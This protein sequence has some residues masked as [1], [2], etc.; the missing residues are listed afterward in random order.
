MS[1][2][3]SD[4]KRKAEEFEEE[5]FG[6]SIEFGV[7]KEKL[8][9]EM[10]IRYI[11][12]DNI[13]NNANNRGKP[14]QEDSQTSSVVWPKRRK[15]QSEVLE[16]HVRA[17]N[18]I[19]ICVRSAKKNST[20]SASFIM[21]QVQN[22]GFYGDDVWLVFDG[23]NRCQTLMDFVDGRTYMYKIMDG[24]HKHN[25][26]YYSD[27]AR[28][29]A[30]QFDPGANHGHVLSAL[31][32]EALMRSEVDVNFWKGTLPECEHQAYLLNTKQTD[33]SKFEEIKIL[34]A[35]DPL[36]T[37][38]KYV[39]ELMENNEFLQAVGMAGEGEKLVACLV[40]KFK[41]H[42]TRIFS[43][44]H[45]SSI[46]EF[47]E[48]EDSLEENNKD[49]VCLVLD[50][51]RT[52][53]AHRIASTDEKRK[54]EILFVM[55]DMLMSK[56]LEIARPNAAAVELTGNLFLKSTLTAKAFP[57]RDRFLK[58]CSDHPACVN[59][60]TKNLVDYLEAKGLV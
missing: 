16:A 26:I 14:Y 49:A 60:R 23:W 30:K 18:P 5:I 9:V 50:V 17:Y 34:L 40:M 21:R 31:H 41:R 53:V 25:R 29:F 42:K 27:E 44:T 8:R 39:R 47:F 3:P 56:Y 46:Q 19:S 57:N 35:K 2:T 24:D 15:N 1:L 58:V 37:R 51:M 54:K 52:E 20:T 43:N 38:K 55:A 6:N 11:R 48:C 7:E 22:R 13:R 10:L 59:L 36:T 33:M 45:T 28:E 12:A 32:Q 4:L